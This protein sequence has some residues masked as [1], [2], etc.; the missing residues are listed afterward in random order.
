MVARMAGS[1]ERDPVSWIARIPTGIRDVLLI[2]DVMLLKFPVACL[3]TSGIL[4]CRGALSDESTLT[5][6]CRLSSAAN[7]AELRPTPIDL[8][9]LRLKLC[10]AVAANS[11]LPSRARGISTRTRAVLRPSIRF[12]SASRAH[13]FARFKP[14]CYRTLRSIHGSSDLR[15]GIAIAT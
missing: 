13:T 15:E 7:G 4:A 14:T 2:D 5:R 3:R 10:T 9:R 6:L 8:A 11:A 1:A 12:R